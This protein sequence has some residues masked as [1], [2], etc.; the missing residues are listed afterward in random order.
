MRPSCSCIDN[1]EADSYVLDVGAGTGRLSLFLAD[2]GCR[3][4]SCDI[5]KEMLHYIDMHKGVRNIETLE[6]SAESIPLADEK[7]DAVVSMDFMP[8]F[9]NWEA[10][11]KEQVRL[12][13]RG[14][15]VM[16]NFLS[17]ENTKVLKNYRRNDGVE[18]NFFAVNYA[19]FA[20]EKQLAEVAGRLGLKV[21]AIY[22]YN[23][24]TA[25]S[26]FGCDLTKKQV[27]DFGA[28]F[29]KAIENEQV[30][31]FVKLFEENI[32][33][34]MPLLSSVTMVVKLRKN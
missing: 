13:K 3:V 10:L 18:S 24:F 33:R 5:S 9:P 22:P 20:N 12:C 31:N 30:M 29:N 14:G 27:D 19:A 28:Q 16:F 26:L 32:V 2:H 23:F 17:S 25:N 11:L 4:L 15:V 34:Y 21:E 7:F 8:H 6:S 1:L